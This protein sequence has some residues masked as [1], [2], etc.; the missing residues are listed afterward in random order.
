MDPPTV[1][2]SRQ[3]R[4]EAR[5]RG[6]NTHKVQDVA[7]TIQTG[8]G[9]G[10]PPVRTPGNRRTVT[11]A[12]TTGKKSGSTVKRNATNAVQPAS[13]KRTPAPQLPA[14]VQR[15]A[16]PST[17]KRSATTAALHPT[18]TSTAKKLSTF[19][20]ASR[21]VGSVRRPTAP[22]VI[23]RNGG[24]DTPSN[25]RA[26]GRRRRQQ[27][28]EGV[29]SPIKKS[30]LGEEVEQEHE[31]Q[32]EGVEESE[33]EVNGD[34][35]EGSA[36]MSLVTE[37]NV[38]MPIQTEQE[39][40]EEIPEV[41]AEVEPEQE[42]PEQPEQPEQESEENVDE[43]EDM[44]STLPTPKALKTNGVSR[45]KTDLPRRDTAN[46]NGDRPVLAP[47]RAPADATRPATSQENG[48]TQQKRKAKATDPTPS[49]T[50]A[51]KQKSR[52]TRP[53]PTTTQQTDST[54]PSQSQSQPP[55]KKA[56][57]S[58][59]VQITTHKFSASNTTRAPTNELDIILALLTEQL[60]RLRQRTTIDARTRL[61][62]D[63]FTEEV[64]IRLLQMTD[65]LDSYHSLVVANR[66]AGRRKGELRA[67]L[68]RVR[69][70]RAG[71]R[72]RMTEVRRQHAEAVEINEEMEGVGRFF[73]EV[74]KMREEDAGEVR[75]A[76]EMK[77]MEGLLRVV[78][79]VV[80]GEYA[81]A[82]RLSVFNGFL[83]RVEEAIRK[84]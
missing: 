46:L 28:P 77:G 35:E 23:P 67:E 79:P 74:V 83:E 61:I 47:G 38:V 25:R 50:P 48:T 64:T 32:Q 17:A 69:R 52:P 81:I 15:P 70:E 66:R 40:D 58:R 73:E 13:A 19:G 18:R 45:S 31:E 30:R 41:E 43:E 82:K 21:G 2:N 53:E 16:A 72:D 62:L 3:E 26:G 80:T 76:E 59:S 44:A 22:A 14:S 10:A 7:F 4:R 29:D 71:V 60:D 56:L 65:A 27:D 12:P 33:K 84:A 8:A 37:E 63:A 39:V 57:E 78:G 42:Q 1:P 11:Q 51:K 49:A 6:A 75:E 24:A 20:P 9:G 68:L 34:G 36:E 55:R 54:L 5:V